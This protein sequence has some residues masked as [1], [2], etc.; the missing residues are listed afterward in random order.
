MAYYIVVG[1]TIVDAVDKEPTDEEIQQIANEMN[2]STY[3]IDGEHCGISAEP[4]KRTETDSM[5]G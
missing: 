5:K 2:G 4:Q 1:G 3:V